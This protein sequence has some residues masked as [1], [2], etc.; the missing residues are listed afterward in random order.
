MFAKGLLGQIAIISMAL[1]TS[2]AALQLWAPKKNLTPPLVGIFLV[3]VVMLGLVTTQELSA[4]TDPDKGRLDFPGLFQSPVAVVKKLQL[5]YYFLSFQLLLG[6]VSI[7][8]RGQDKSSSDQ[9]Q[10]QTMTPKSERR[11]SRSCQKSCI[12]VSWL[13]A[14]LV[15]Q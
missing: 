12:C 15:R 11:M 9:A 3:S 8:A 1:G 13:R 4:L 10:P 7:N 2:L 5:G 14:A 6:I